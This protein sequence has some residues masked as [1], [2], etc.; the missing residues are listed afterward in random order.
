[1]ARSSS[2]VVTT[3]LELRD[4]LA[5]DALSMAAIDA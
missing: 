1:M 4:T 5:S 2:K 3:L